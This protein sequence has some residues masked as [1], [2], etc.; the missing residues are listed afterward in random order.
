MSGGVNFILIQLLLSYR[1]LD[2]TSTV[3]VD[4]SIQTEFQQYNEDHLAADYIESVSLK[5]DD[6]EY[7][8]ETVGAKM[9]NL[10]LNQKSESVFEHRRNNVYNISDL[11]TDMGYEITD[12]KIGKYW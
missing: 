11:I 6:E 1:L 12:Y 8:I 7:W 10:I 5:K 2:K 4:I 3:T 9:V